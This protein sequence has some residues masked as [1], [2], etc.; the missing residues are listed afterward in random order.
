M[1]YLVCNR[2]LTSQVLRVINVKSRQS[3]RT[4]VISCQFRFFL[5]NVTLRVPVFLTMSTRVNRVISGRNFTYHNQYGRYSFLTLLVFRTRSRVATLHS[6]QNS[7]F[8]AR[9]TKVSTVLIRRFFTIQYS[10]IQSGS[11]YTHAIK[12]GVKRR[13]KRRRF[14]R[15]ETASVANT[16]GRSFRSLLLGGGAVNFTVLIFRW[17]G[18][19]KGART[20]S[21]T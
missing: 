9:T 21:W 13:L 8:H 6:L 4:Y 16:S 14:S 3:S 7:P 19:L 12:F 20:P 5:A 17:V 2:I 15:E 18:K 11:A 1:H 10:F